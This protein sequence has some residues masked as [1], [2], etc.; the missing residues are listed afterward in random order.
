[1][2]LSD[3][4]DLLERHG[5]Q[6]VFKNKLLENGEIVE[7]FNSEYDINYAVDVEKL[8]SFLEKTQKKNMIKLHIS[9]DLK[10]NLLK[11]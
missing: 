1:M 3:M 5:F 4:M 7:G 8:F 6:R 10:L 9:L 2:G 11:D